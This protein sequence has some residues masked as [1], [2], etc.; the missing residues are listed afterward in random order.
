MPAPVILPVSQRCGGSAW[1]SRSCDC[2]ASAALAEGQQTPNPRVQDEF[3]AWGTAL[4]Q[5][6]KPN[7]HKRGYPKTSAPH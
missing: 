6:H 2:N 7:K 4:N 3:A 1:A 5:Q